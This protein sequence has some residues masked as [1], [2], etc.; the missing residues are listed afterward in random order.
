MNRRFLGL[1]L[2]LGALAI[3]AVLPATGWLVRALLQA[4]VAA[5]LWQPMPRI[6]A[7]ADAAP[8][9]TLLLVAAWGLT[10]LLAVLLTGGVAGMVLRQSRFWLQGE[11][12]RGVEPVLLALFL[13]GTAWWG[14]GATQLVGGSRLVGA[15]GGVVLLLPVGVGMLA[16][17]LYWGKRGQGSAVR[18]LTGLTAVS[19]P[20]SFALSLL[21][22]GILAAV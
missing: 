19:L 12:R 8:H 17:A 9:Q 11:L 1:G 5:A 4:I 15:L 13:L 2:A 7:P 3:V 21:C 18:L 6:S 10:A 20:T 22:A 16:L 14:A